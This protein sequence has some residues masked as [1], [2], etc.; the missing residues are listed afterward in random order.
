MGQGEFGGRV[1]HVDRARNQV[2]LVVLNARLLG[3]L[4]SA[5]EAVRH[6]R[7]EIEPS[8]ADARKR[9]NV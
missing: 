2:R 7:R 1:A 5:Q 3:N 8:S 6:D 9:R 4:K